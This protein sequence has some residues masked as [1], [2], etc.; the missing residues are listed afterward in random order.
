MEDGFQGWTSFYCIGMYWI[1]EGWCML[2]CM[3]ELS[4]ELENTGQAELS[5]NPL[6]R[7]KYLNVQVDLIIQ[8]LT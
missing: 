5:L 7:A 4:K 1:L 3:L 2:C 8:A 6:N